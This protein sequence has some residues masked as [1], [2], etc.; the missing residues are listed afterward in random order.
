MKLRVALVVLAFGWPS[1]AGFARVGSQSQDIGSFSA[2]KA[3]AK[4]RV[5]ALP[6]RTVAVTPGGRSSTELDFRVKPGFHINSNKPGSQLLVPTELKLSPP[7]NIL[8]GGV[9][10]PA[11]HDFSLS[12]APTEKLNVYTGDFS[13]NAL[14]NAARHISPGLYR[15]HGFL[16]YQAC[17]DRACYPPAKLPVAFDVRVTRAARHHRNTPQ[18]PDIHR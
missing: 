14:V 16:Q 6:P 15:V 13:L 18:S 12:A 10:Y 4:N 17:D 7:T 8:V 3:S 1:L 2:P 5:E 11:G 9:E